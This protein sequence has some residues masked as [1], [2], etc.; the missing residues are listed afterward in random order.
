MHFEDEHPLQRP[1]PVL[2]DRPPRRRYV[3]LH[4]P[5]CPQ[6]VVGL[7]PDHA[8]ALLAIHREGTCQHTG[9]GDL[10]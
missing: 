9:G 10:G 6:V 8:A 2:R 1:L 5:D 7:D 3:R 4:C